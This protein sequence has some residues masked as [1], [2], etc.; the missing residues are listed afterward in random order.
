M[1]HHPTCT[2]VRRQYMALLALH[3]FLGVRCRMLLLVS[4]KL[5]GLC[6]VIHL[7]NKDQQYALFL[8]IYFNNHPLYISNR[9]TIQEEVY[10]TC[11]LLYMQFTVLAVYCNA[12]YCTCSL[13]NM[14]FTVPAI[15]CT[16]SLLYMQFTENAVYCTCSLL[17]MQFTVHAVYWTCSLL[18]LQFTVHAVYCNCNL[19]YMQ[20]TLHAVYCTCS[21]LN[22]QFTVHAV[23]CTCSLLYMQFTV[24]AVYCTCSSTLI[25]LAA[26]QRGCVINTI[27]CIYSKLPADDE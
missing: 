9:L 10:C 20:F 14:Q 23:Y 7:C 2:A 19:L 4:L 1:K 24:H 22:M 17:Y 12:V 5:C 3:C 8:L 6:I 11:S 21:L 13:L 26:S 15:Y 18:Y 16:W 27:Y 25:V